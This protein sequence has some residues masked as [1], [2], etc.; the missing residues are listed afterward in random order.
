MTKERLGIYVHIPFCE[1]KCYYCG[2]LSFDDREEEDR[3][4]YVSYL[5]REIELWGR[6]TSSR[7]LCDS[8][9]IGG[10]TPS[11]LKTGGISEIM[12]KLRDVFP[13]SEEA[14]VSI[15]GN[16]NSLTSEKL[17][18]YKEAGIN[19]LSI[20]VQSLHDE[21]LKRLG[22][23]HRREDVFRA[24]EDGRRAGF[25]NINLDLMFGVPDQKFSSW[26][27]D[28]EEVLKLNP[29]HLSLYSIQLEEGSRFYED[30]RLGDLEFPSEKED[31]KMFHYAVKELKDA[32]YDHYEISNFGRRKCK[33]NLKYWSFDNYLGIGLGASSYA[34]GMRSRNLS[35]IELWEEKIEE[36]HIPVDREGRIRDSRKDA[37]AIYCF[38]ALRKKEGIDFKEFKELF[39]EEFSDYHRG[40]WAVLKGYERE[41]LLIITG[42]RLALTEAGIDVSN[43]IMAE[44][45][46]ENE[47]R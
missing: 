44:F 20:G 21:T 32:G 47:K 40:R 14:E 12:E 8:I 10:G 26:A 18:E 6:A 4:R 45:V 1:R 46:E 35:T 29:E 15:E 42:Q 38:T 7:Y 33:H 22:R 36:G 31:R 27:R 37:V 16:P 30:Y 23:V 3:E 39:D 24:Y 13:M 25:D 19:R 41:G 5:L 43:E 34:D 9:F 11:L 28:V 17:K 2:F